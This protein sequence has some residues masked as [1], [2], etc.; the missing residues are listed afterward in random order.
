MAKFGDLIASY[1]QPLALVAVLAV[2]MLALVWRARERRIRREQRR[3][4]R[5]ARQR[6]WDWLMLRPQVR[7]LTHQPKDDQI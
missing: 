2:V 4:R 7:R 1:G 6:V 5:L 3:V